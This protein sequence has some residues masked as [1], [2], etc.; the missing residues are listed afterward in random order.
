VFENIRA[1]LE[2]VRCSSLVN[3]PV[4]P[5]L[6]R[7]M[8]LLALARNLQAQIAKIGLAA[9]SAAFFLQCLTAT[10]PPTLHSD[11]VYVE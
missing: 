6:K 8:R 2:R 3:W 7:T 5:R 4:Y 9:F 10:P 11:T 1:A